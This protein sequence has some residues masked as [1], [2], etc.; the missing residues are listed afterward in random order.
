MANAFC[1][2]QHTLEFTA[3]I[4]GME[5][6]EEITLL[7]VE[8]IEFGAFHTLADF[9]EICV[10]VGLGGIEEIESEVKIF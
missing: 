2:D 5:F 9:F 8:T 7:V 1:C 6:D 10:G 3:G 4:V